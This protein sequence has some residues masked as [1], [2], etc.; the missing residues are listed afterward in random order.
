MRSVCFLAVVTSCITL[1]AQEV[2]KTFVVSNKYI[3]FPVSQSTERQRVI[4]QEPGIP[5][6]P[7]QMRIAKGTPDYWVFRDV[8][9]LMGKTITLSFSQKVSGIDS[10]FQGDSYPGEDSIYRESRRPQVHFSPRRGWN[11]DPNGL[12]Y[13]Q[14]LYHLFF[15]HN[16]YERDWENM[17]WGHA[18]SRDLMHWEEWPL[19]LFPDTLG[20]MFSGSAVI[21][22]QN[23]AG[24]GKDA[25][26]AVYTA[27]G[28]KMTQNVA[29]SLDNGK[30]FTKY[31]G[32]PLLGPDRDP[33]VFWYEPGRHWVMAVYNENHID[34]YNSKDLKKWD[35]KS[36]TKGFFECP[37]LFELPVDGNSGNK[38]W[39]MY[40]ASGTY[41]IGSFDGS[42]FTPEK[43]KYHYHT[44]VQY[45]AQT[46][47]NTPDGRRVQ[48]GWGRVDP[49]IQPFNQMML[50]P[51][52][53]SLRTTSEG[54]RL[55]CQ[56]IKEI[57]SLHTRHLSLSGLS[58]EAANQQLA[59]LK[60]VLVHAVMDLEM[61]K[62]L[63]LE[64]FYQDNPILYYDGNYTKF[65]GMPYES[66]RPGAFRFRI[67]MILDRTSVEGYIDG[68]K[69]FVAEALKPARS[70]KGLELRGDLKIHQLDVYELQSIWK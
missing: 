64:I 53:L 8:S 48:I 60:T 5:A 44:G 17:H 16:P 14:G 13:H 11:N 54:V 12:V 36:Q 20:T 7:L 49:M 1:N 59:Q 46:Y 6:Y 9:A 27:A 43:G 40:A 41:M 33:K 62:G 61:D 68:G 47:N 23:T 26:V 25:L 55:F 19:A 56:P 3:N 24:W 66:E 10:I 21:D 63:G 31:A 57:S 45:A 52:E 39:V 30:T 65:N 50:F 15:Q 69:L 29:Y 4:F 38:K 58:V 37:E 28:K 42:A 51:T 67:E 34:I 35:Y 22:K 2:S 18:V 70:S 32:N